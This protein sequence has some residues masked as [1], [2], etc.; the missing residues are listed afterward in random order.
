[1]ANRNPKK[2]QLERPLIQIH[3]DRATLQTAVGEERELG[4][5]SVTE[6]HD[7]GLH[8]DWI[9]SRLHD[10]TVREKVLKREARDVGFQGDTPVDEASILLRQGEELRA[11][12]VDPVRALGLRLGMERWRRS[13][14]LIDDFVHALYLVA[15]DPKWLLHPAIQAHIACTVQAL[16]AGTPVDLATAKRAST[17]PAKDDAR[18]R[19]R[20]IAN[21]LLLEEDP[22]AMLERVSRASE[23]QG[24]IAAHVKESG[25]VKEAM[26]DGAKGFGFKSSA[27]LR[28][29]LV[30]AKRLQDE[31]GDKLPWV[32]FEFP[33]RKTR[34]S[35]RKK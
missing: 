31:H 22:G 30:R 5:V 18:H 33:P 28:Q 34:T 27:A 12:G 3:G 29:E 35:R 11:L 4:P 14:V 2:T 6:T 9:L 8:P 20:Q 19:M 1:M 21:A 26:R 25:S 7:L 32:G 16:R 13:Q 24:W 17:S 15:A 23:I 10:K